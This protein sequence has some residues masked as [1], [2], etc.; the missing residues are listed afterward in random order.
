MTRDTE[1][2]SDAR[3]PAGLFGRIMGLMFRPAL[4]RGE[5]LLLEPCSSIHTAF[6]RFPIDVVYLDNNE[7]VVKARPAIKPFRVSAAFGGARSVL[8]LPAGT[9]E[10][11]GTRRGDQLSLDS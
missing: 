7:R 6:M 9:I 11:T 3:A 2:A 10:R 4:S 1:V 5:A 8:E